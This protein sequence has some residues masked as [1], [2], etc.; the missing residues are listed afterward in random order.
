MTYRTESQSSP[1]ASSTGKRGVDRLP[2]FRTEFPPAD[3]PSLA[4]RNVTS[5]R[6][7]CIGTHIQRK[8]TPENASTTRFFPRRR[9]ITVVIILLSTNAP[10]S[11]L[12]SVRFR[13]L[14]NSRF[15]SAPFVGTGGSDGRRAPPRWIYLGL[16]R[17]N[18]MYGNGTGEIS[19]YRW[20]R[21][22]IR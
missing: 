13:C 11:H 9:Y 18:L 17:P 19:R 5:I 14:R 22:V 20:R 8:C 21:D 3:C 10:S 15:C 7:K 6:T 2:L 4:S 12:F 1:A 16:P